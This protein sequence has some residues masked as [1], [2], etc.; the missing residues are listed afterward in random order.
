ML[1]KVAHL[2]HLLGTIQ[3]H[4]FLRDKLALKGGTAL[5][6][7]LFDVPRLSVDIDLNY[8]GAGPRD[9]M[10]AERP[11]PEEALGA[12]FARGAFQ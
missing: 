2:L 10:M 3:T 11:K 4:P 8:V 9:E 1:E 12:V 5:N 7:F 6:L